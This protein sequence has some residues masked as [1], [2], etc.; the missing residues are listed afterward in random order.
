[1]LFRSANSYE[2]KF[3]RDA[4]YNDN[5]ERVG[6]GNMD[7]TVLKM[8]QKRALVAASLFIG[9]LSD[10]FTQDFDDAD[11]KDL[12][13]NDA[14]TNS[15]ED[16]LEK[17]ITKSQANRMYAISS[18]NGALCKQIIAQFGYS[19]SSEVKVKDYEAICKEIEKQIKQQ[20]NNG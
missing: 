7:N 17:P 1:M 8:A 11:L 5:G 10:V 14:K 13:G 6:I 18:G 9:N 2:T 3:Q 20:Q 15:I 16:G 12:N 4:K 19:S